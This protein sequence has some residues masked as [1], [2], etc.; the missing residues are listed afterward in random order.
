MGGLLITKIRVRSQSLLLSS[1]HLHNETEAKGG[2]AQVSLMLFIAP[3]SCAS[4]RPAPAPARY[5]ICLCT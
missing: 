5:I 1:K 3:P 2:L 4:L